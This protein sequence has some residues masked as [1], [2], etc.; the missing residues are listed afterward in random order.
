[1]HNPSEAVAYLSV[2]RRT[3]PGRPVLVQEFLPGTEYS[4]ALIGNPGI[5]LTALPIME[6]DYS[7]LPADLP[8]ILGY[9][10]KWEPDT[11]YWTDIAYREAEIDEDLRRNMV[12][13]SSALFERLGCRDYARF[14]FRADD[15]V[16][17]CHLYDYWSL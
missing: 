6:V 3:L 15:E 5:G 13:W 2:L 11:A 17:R 9:E 8:K 4:V 12:D 14:D 7:R 1:M 16:C 10:S